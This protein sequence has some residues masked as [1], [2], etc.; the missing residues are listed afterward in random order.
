MGRALQDAQEGGRRVGGVVDHAAKLAATVEVALN[1]KLHRLER[2]GKKDVWVEI[3]LADLRLLTSDNP[4]WV[5]N[6]YRNVLG[7]A[8]EQTRESV[9][10]QLALYH[11]LGV[12]KANVDAIL[13]YTAL[14]EEKGD[15]DGRQRVLIFTG[16]M[17]DSA[18]RQKPRFPKDKEGIARQKIK[19]A[20]ESEMKIGEG[21]S[22]GI[23]GGA[24]GGDILFHEVCHEL[25]VPTY[26]YLALPSGLYVT[27][28][29]RKAGPDWVQ[30]FRDL[31]S[32]LLDQGRVRILSYME[33]EP[34]D[35]REYLPVWLRSKPNYNI[36]QRNNLWMLNNALTAGGDDC[37][38]LIALWDCEPTGDGPGGTS[39]L[40]ARVD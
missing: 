23:A 15:G 12:L 29:V 19:E 16:H 38:T 24:S 11:E 17:I 6:G 21:V 30:R 10:K 27:K 25:G 39:D 36:W 22:F 9:R 7:E 14:P 20:V 37:V 40:V 2:E 33:E 31:Y 5:V 3:S 34:K 13:Q 1:A 35:D 28:S 18:D 8:S 26:L 32:R 4:E